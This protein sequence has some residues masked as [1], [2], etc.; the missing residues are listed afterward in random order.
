M[1]VQDQGD[2]FGEWLFRVSFKILVLNLGSD[3]KHEPNSGG[4]AYYHYWSYMVI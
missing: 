2:L 3:G 1:P 4:K